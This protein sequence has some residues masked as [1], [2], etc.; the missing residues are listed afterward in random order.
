MKHFSR[1]MTSSIIAV[2]AVVAVLTATT[3]AAARASS[4]GVDAELP[5][6][7]QSYPGGGTWSYGVGPINVYSHYHH[8]RSVH[9]ATACAGAK[10]GYS[11][12]VQAGITAVAS[13]PKARSG[14][15]AY[16]NVR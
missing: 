2:S 7:H 10:C 5:G 1:T 14:N 15:T 13:H 11:G 12:W 6:L 4:G 9:K 3:P 16:W 8:A